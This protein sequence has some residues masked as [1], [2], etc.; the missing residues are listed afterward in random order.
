MGALR[1][2]DFMHKQYGVADGKCGECCHFVKAWYHTRMLRKCKVYGLTHSEASE[3]AGRWT[4]CGLFN[5]PT[6]HQNVIR[7]VKRGAKETVEIDG[8]QELT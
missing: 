3:W 1:K 2:I 6:N 7:T 5:C 4:A 8:Q